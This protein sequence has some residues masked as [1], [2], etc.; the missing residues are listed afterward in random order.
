MSNQFENYTI[1]EREVLIKREVLDDLV[2]SRSM[3]YRSLHEQLVDEYG[4]DIKYNSFMSLVQ[5]KNTWKLV[6]AWVI[7]EFFKS[8]I[9]DLFELVVVDKNE[10]KKAIK[11]WNEKYNPNYR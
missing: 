4:I 10:K 11:E 5:N 9:E 8:T 2:K 1:N 6:Y 3:T 7:S